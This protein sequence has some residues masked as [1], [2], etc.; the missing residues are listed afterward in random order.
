M[1]YKGEKGGNKQEAPKV[2]SR[3][4][5][6]LVEL[7][8]QELRDKGLSEEQIEAILQRRYAPDDLR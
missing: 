6:H 8:R 7:A 1:P 4:L 5:A 3:A 2:G